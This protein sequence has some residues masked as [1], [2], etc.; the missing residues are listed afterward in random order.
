MLVT[1]VNGTYTFSFNHRTFW[2]W[3]RPCLTVGLTDWKMET[4]E[5]CGAEFSFQQHESTKRI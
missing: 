3:V 2:F 1:S 5:D 4:F